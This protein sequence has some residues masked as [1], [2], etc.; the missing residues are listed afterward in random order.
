MADGDPQIAAWAAWSLVHGFTMLQLGGALPLPP[1]AE[2][3][4]VARQVVQF[5]AQ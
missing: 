5:L 2:P 4:D 1:D 3:E